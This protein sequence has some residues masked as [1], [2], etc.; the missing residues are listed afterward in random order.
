VRQGIVAQ[1]AGS[2]AVCRRVRRHG[3]DI[4]SSGV[5]LPPPCG[6]VPAARQEELLVSEYVTLA[7]MCAAISEY[8]R[9][10]RFGLDV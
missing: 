8:Y 1:D 5:A 2:E 3:D 6:G 10:A 9:T 7:A 4:P